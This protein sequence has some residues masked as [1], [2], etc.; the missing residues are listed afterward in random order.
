MMDSSDSERGFQMKGRKGFGFTGSVILILCLMVSVLSCT[1]DN[2]EE[3]PKLGVIYGKVNVK[4]SSSN[5]GVLITARSTD[6]EYRY[7]TTSDSEGAFRIEDV[8]P[9]TYRVVLSKEGYTD[10]SKVFTVDWDDSVN[11]RTI[12]LSPLPEMIPC[13]VKW[14]GIRVSTYGM[15]SFGKDNFPDETQMAGFVEKMTSCY[16]GS[17]GA[18]ILIV[19]T[20]SGDSCGLNFPVEG[21]YDYIR[22][23]KNDLYDSYLD[24]F[25]EMGYSVWL[26]VEPGDA[27]LVTL[28]TLVMNQYSHHS[29]VKGF[30]IDVEWHK[31]VENSDAGTKLSDKDAKAVLAKI[32]EYNPEYTLFVKHWMRSYLPSRMDGLIYVNDSQQFGSMDEVLTDFSEWARYYAPQPVMFQIGYRADSWIWNTYDNPAKEFGQAIVDECQSGNDVGIIWVDFTLNQVI[33]KIVLESDPE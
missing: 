4:E 33:D 23:S 1:L 10:E 19:G 25:D 26:Q 15:R 5:E 27:D 20:V 21:N 11:M 31:P 29:C 17:E 24:K 14:A 16:E 2:Q 28:A 12:N 6:G 3:A 9:S 18:Y 7:T 22:G 30:G 13:T 32:R 8:Y